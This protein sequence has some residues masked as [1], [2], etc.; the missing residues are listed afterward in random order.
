VHPRILHDMSVDN[1]GEREDRWSAAMSLDYAPV[2]VRATAGKIRPGSNYLARQDLEDF[3]LLELASTTCS[4]QRPRN[5]RRN[6]AADHVALIFVG[7]GHETITVG[8]KRARL[9]T[10]DA[11]VWDPTLDTLFEVHGSVLKYNLLVPRSALRTVG[12]SSTPTSGILPRTPTT[13]LLVVL[14]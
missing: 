6:D 8:G 13:R 10:G 14:C 11:A 7:Q 4:A 9:S 1:L 5:L 2:E 3:R 12:A